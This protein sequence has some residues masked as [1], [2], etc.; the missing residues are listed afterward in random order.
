VVNWEAIREYL[1]NS[2]ADEAVAKLCF[3]LVDKDIRGVV[4]VAQFIKM[5]ELARAARVAPDIFYKR[6]YDTVDPQRLG[7]IGRRQF[8]ELLGKLG[9]SISDSC[10]R[11]ILSLSDGN[12]LGWISFKSFWLLV[13]T[14]VSD[15]KFEAASE[16]AQRLLPKIRV[17][18]V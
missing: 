11:E 4:D 17:S 18:S 3:E 16:E 9:H 2:E 1:G 15:E 12:G 5:M 6:V 13:T 14:G 8:V 7:V 10:A